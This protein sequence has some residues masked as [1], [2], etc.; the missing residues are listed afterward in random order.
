MDADDDDDEDAPIMPNFRPHL[1]PRANSSGGSGSPSIDNVPHED[2][3]E[4]DV[5]TAAGDFI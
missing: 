2:T 1:Y 5:I 3:I 4:P